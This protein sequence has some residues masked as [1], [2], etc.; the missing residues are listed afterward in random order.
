MP[1]DH[2]LIGAFLSSYGRALS[3]G[4][5]PAIVAYW[6]IPSLVV[7]DAGGRAVTAAAEVEAFFAGAAAW[8]QAQGL[9]ATRPESWT[10][11]GLSPALWSVDVRW[12]ALNRD[13]VWSPSDHSQYILRS[14]AEGALVISVA[15]TLPA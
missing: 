6:D 11:T 15:I 14:T 13:G 12:S 4:D 8:Y 2:E 3:A 10:V 9:L 1:T 7:H 5:L